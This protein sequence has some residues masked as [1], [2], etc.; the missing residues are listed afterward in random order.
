MMLGWSHDD[1]HRLQPASQSSPKSAPL[2][3]D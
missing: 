3:V 2:A 1:R